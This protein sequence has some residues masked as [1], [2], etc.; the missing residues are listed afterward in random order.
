VEVDADDPI[1]GR[2]NARRAGGADARGGAGDGDESLR[3]LGA[4]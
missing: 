2:D 1:A 3:Q 4:P